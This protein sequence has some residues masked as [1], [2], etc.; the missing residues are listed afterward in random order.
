MKNEAGARPTFYWS[1]FSTSTRKISKKE[2]PGQLVLFGTVDKTYIKT[3]LPVQLIARGH[4]DPYCNIKLYNS[5]YLR[6]HVTMF[7]RNS[8][9]L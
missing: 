3:C 1:T 7:R 8:N 6:G 2:S 4:V 5:V 9:Y